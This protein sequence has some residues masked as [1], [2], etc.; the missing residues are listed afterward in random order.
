MEAWEGNTCFYLIFSA[1][2]LN[3]PNISYPELQGVS[4]SPCDIQ[5]TR[6]L[7]GILGVDIAPSLVCLLDCDKLPFICTQLSGC[8][9]YFT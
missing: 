4:L 9:D 2:K 8:I 7:Y 1:K 6:H 3:F 5:L